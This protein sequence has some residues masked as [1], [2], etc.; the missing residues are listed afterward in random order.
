MMRLK[1]AVAS[2][3]TASV[4]AGLRAQP[5]PAPTELIHP[6][7]TVVRFVFNV[8]AMDV[9]MFDFAGPNGAPPAINTV[10]HFLDQFTL[11]LHDASFVHR[12]VPD[13]FLPTHF[14]I[15]GGGFTFT[16]AHGLEAIIADA[17]ANEFHPGRSNLQWTMA[18]ALAAGNPN[19]GTS[20]WFINMVDNEF[21][22]PQLFTVFGRLVGQAGVNERNF[23]IA[24]TIANRDFPGPQ[25][26]E[27]RFV[28]ADVMVDVNQRPVVPLE[29]LP[30]GNPVSLALMDVPVI[31]VPDPIPPGELRLPAMRE[32][33]LYRLLS[34]E[35]IRSCYADCDQSTGPRTL[36]IFDFLCFG[37]RF[38]G[39]DPY[40]CDCDTSTGRGVCDIF[41]FLCFGNAFD[42]GCH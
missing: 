12:Y 24:R 17:I 33:F 31:E 28:F 29:L 26:V 37:N 11:G 30:G 14:V 7:N 2:A 34:I 27:Q 36:D 18:V 22:D 5:Y 41:D 40:A 20:Q 8:G 21:L 16:D 13:L 1:I 4:A 35:V 3:L 23:D 19:S 25:P 39:N 42:A 32:R 15:Q 9:E 6:R 38:A 10:D